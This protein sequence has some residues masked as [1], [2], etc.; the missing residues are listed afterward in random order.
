M[1]NDKKLTEKE[2]K[3]KE[4]LSPPNQRYVIKIS[5]PKIEE[6]IKHIDPFFPSSGLLNNGL[7]S[8]H[9]KSLSFQ[10][11]NFINVSKAIISEKGAN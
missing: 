10:G 1:K 6:N 5:N 3:N 4:I 8:Y 9:V 2:Y 7:K 11:N